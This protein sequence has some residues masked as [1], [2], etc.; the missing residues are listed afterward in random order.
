LRILQKIYATPQPIIAESY[1]SIGQM[2][3]LTSKYEKALQQFEE[4]LKIRKQILHHPPPPLSPPPPSPSPRGEF[5]PPSSPRLP[6]PLSTP[7]E[8]EQEIWIAYT[9]HDCV[10]VLMMDEKYE[11]AKP[12]AIEGLRLRN[13]LCRNTNSLLVAESM[14]QLACIHTALEEHEEST[15]LLLEALEIRLD[16]LGPLALLV[17]ELYH[18]LGENYQ[19]RGMVLEAEEMFLNALNLHFKVYD[20]DDSEEAANTYLE[21]ALL[22]HGNESYDEALNYFFLA[23]EML[24]RL[25]GL[26]NLLVAQCLSKMAYTLRKAERYDESRKRY[27]QASAILHNV[28]QTKDHLEIASVLASLSSLSYYLKDYEDALRLSKQVYGI[29]RKLLGHYHVD[30]ISTLANQAQISAKLGDYKEGLDAMMRVYKW[31]QINLES[32]DPLILQSILTISDLKRKIGNLEDALTFNDLAIG[33]ILN[34]TNGPQSLELMERYAF[35][36]DIK[37]IQGQYHIAEKL[38]RKVVFQ[39]TETY[40]SHHPE[41]AHYMYLFATLL[42][43]M[44]KYDEADRLYKLAFQSQIEVYGNDSPVAASTLNNIGVMYVDQDRFQDAEKLFTEALSIRRATFGNDHP[45]IAASL[46]NLAGLYDIRGRYAEAKELYEESL[47]MRCRLFGKSHP[48]LAQSLNNLG[49]LKCSMGAFED[50]QLF[51]NESLEILR[52]TYGDSHPDVASAM[53]NIA[54]NTHTPLL[55]L[56]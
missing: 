14:I 4:A 55:I 26:E 42:K 15:P 33:M 43:K 48:S 12:Y 30:V 10:K 23:L 51:Y 32:S 35:A 2:Y 45:D 19:D 17:A 6:P 46:N 7:E 49:N 53:N 29:R 28:F 3:L 36:A 1:E 56:L 9:L 16:E 44:G 20:E 24:I 41:T 37:K 54:G 50:A 11:E 47:R 13:I 8:Q 40:G 21:L 31:R 18:L 39:F 5:S 25:Y 22:F 34:K 38:L 27:E 52:K